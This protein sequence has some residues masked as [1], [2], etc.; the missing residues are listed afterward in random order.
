MTRN[1]AREMLK[2][3]LKWIL[4]RTNPSYRIS[5]NNQKQME[6]LNE[7]INQIKICNE[8][9][10]CEIT[11]LQKQLG[12]FQKHKKGFSN[13]GFRPWLKNIDLEKRILEIGPLFSPN[14]KKENCKNVFYA[15]IRTTEEVKELYKDH[16]TVPN[17]EIVDIDYVIR[18]SYYECFNGI[19][20]FDYVVLTHVIEHIPQLISYFQDIATIM[21]TN[22]KICLTIPDKRYCF[23]H[24]RCPTSFSECYD[25]YKR[26]IKNLPYRVLDQVISS[27]INDPVYWWNNITS[28]EH[29]P[30]D[31]YKNEGIYQQAI[32][33]K[34]IDVH[35]SVFTPETFLIFIYNMVEFNLFPYRCV[36]F[37]TTEENTFEFNCV[38]EYEPN[39]QINGSM[40]NKEEKVKLRKLI[41]ENVDT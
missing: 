35:F 24:F 4:Y 8:E 38:L 17:D 39:I 11:I 7:N 26:G 13:F 40:E 27:T 20:K 16:K 12:N 31:R 32:N 21:N 36:E 29:L 2:N 25:I 5:K 18:D 23:D 28:Y 33:G 3:T 10:K 15:D 41:V 1:V 30:N 14:I 37:Y 9:I 22:G 19:E 6:V 34:Y